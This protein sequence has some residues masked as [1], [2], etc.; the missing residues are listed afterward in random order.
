[1]RKPSIDLPAHAPGEAG[2]RGGD[3]ERAELE[4]RAGF[5]QVAEELSVAQLR[6]TWVR[7]ARQLVNCSIGQ[8]KRIDTSCYN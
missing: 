2:A 7:L 1:M 3:Q 4:A 8:R 6:V 5:T